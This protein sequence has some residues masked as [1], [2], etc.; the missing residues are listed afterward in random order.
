MLSEADRQKAADILV[1][2]A[3]TRKQ[4]TQLSVT[5]P[6]I[7]FEDAYAISTICAKRRGAAGEKLIGHKV[8][9]TSKAMQQSSQ[10]DEP[11]YG[12]LFDSMMVADG[13]KVPHENYCAPRVEVEREL[14]GRDARLPQ[15]LVGV[16]AVTALR[17][18]AP[19]RGVRVVE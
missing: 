13:A 9:L 10:I 5:F 15:E 19:G 3:K 1:E 4:A 2:A 16:V 14:C 6:G 7:T 11:D 12:Y 8:G 18:H 17:R